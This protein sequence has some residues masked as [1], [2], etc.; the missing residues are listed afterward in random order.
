MPSEMPHTD[1]RGYEDVVL[2]ALP[3]GKNNFE[4]KRISF[5][6]AHGK[7]LFINHLIIKIR[8]HY[9]K[10]YLDYRNGGA[11]LRHG[12]LLHS[13]TER[14]YHATNRGPLRPG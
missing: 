10:T 7:Q 12:R 9:E 4:R 14:G 8:Y 6:F 11:G 13:I 3:D 5:I 1:V 2:S